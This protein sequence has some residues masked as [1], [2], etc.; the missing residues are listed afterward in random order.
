MY[1]V[2]RWWCTA[3][4]AAQREAGMKPGARNKAVT[5]HE[6]PKCLPQSRLPEPYLECVEYFPSIIITAE[7]SRY[8]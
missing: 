5:T 4:K 6:E 3:I 8:V 2:V 1:P 7:A